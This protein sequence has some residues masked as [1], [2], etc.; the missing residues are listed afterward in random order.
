VHTLHFLLDVGDVL[1]SDSF[2][3]KNPTEKQKVRTIPINGTS[4]NIPYNRVITMIEK[5]TSDTASLI[6]FVS[7]PF[8]SEY[9]Y[10]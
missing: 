7:F 1:G 8:K 2:T 9:Q 4:K 5:R 3:T 6:I 10:Q